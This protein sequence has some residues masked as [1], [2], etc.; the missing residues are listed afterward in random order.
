MRW[1]RRND[2]RPQ[3]LTSRQCDSGSNAR[4]GFYKPINMIDGLWQ[5]T[6]SR[7]DRCYNERNGASSTPNSES[8][9][10]R[11]CAKSMKSKAPPADGDLQLTASRMSMDRV[12]AKPS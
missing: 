10:A 3:S 6:C 2:D 7:C 4:P 1:R 5:R 9:L 8:F 11:A 12:A